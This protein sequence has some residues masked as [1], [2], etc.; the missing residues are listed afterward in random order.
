MGLSLSIGG[1]RIMVRTAVG[2]LSL[3]AALSL[4]KSRELELFPGREVWLAFAQEALEW[5]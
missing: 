5:L 3:T 2:G 1:S 4:D